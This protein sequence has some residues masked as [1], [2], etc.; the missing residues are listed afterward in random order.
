MFLINNIYQATEG[1]GTRIGTPQVFV[2][3]QGCAIG[4]LNC[5]SKETWGFYEETTMSLE[6]IISKVNTFSI[7]KKIKWVSITGG[8]PLHPT[9]E[10]VLPELISALKK[11]GYLINIEASG[12]RVVEPIFNSVDFISF[13]YKTPSTGVKT[14]YANLIK[15]TT[16]YANKS[17]VKAVVANRHDFDSTLDMFF[18]V[19]NELSSNLPW[20][21]TPCYEPCS[22]IKKD[23]VSDIYSW[24][25]ESG[26]NFRVIGQQHKWFFGPNKRDI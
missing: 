6:D 1:E 11:E 13:D 15:L 25:I 16:K 7:N 9:H 8:D 10:K 2:R 17:Q 23:F 22:I 26:S 19:N 5:D 14:N 20:V 12:S 24:N 18:K 21:I 4:C 3:F